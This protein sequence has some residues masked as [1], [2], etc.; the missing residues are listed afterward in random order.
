MSDLFA[1]PLEEMIEFQDLKTDLQ[2]G[3]GPLLVTG[4]LDSQKV[5]LLSE[6]SDLTPWKLIVTYDDSRAREICEDYRCFDTDISLYPARDLLFYTSDIHGNLLTKQRIQVM[7]RILESSGGVVVT[8]IDGLMEH[9]LP[10]AWMKERSLTI[11]AED[12][13][14]VGKLTHALAEMGYE[15]VA[16]VEGSG[17]FS[18]R[19]GIID[20]FPLTEEVPYRI[21]LWG[22]E[23][24]SIRTFDPESQRSIEQ[25]DEAVIYP[26]TEMALTPEQIQDG[27]E[28]IE[29]DRR[30]Y[31]K[32]LRDAM[33]TEEA[34]RMDS[35]VSEVLEGL[36]EGFR[37]HG[38]GSYIRYFCKET[39]SFL[40][41]FPADELTIFLDEPLRLKEKAETTETE[42][43]ESMSHRLEGG[44]L[45][46]GQ[47][48]FLYSAKETLAMAMR[49]RTLLLLGLDQKLSGMT[50]KKK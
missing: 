14:E 29:K 32:K 24:D 42:F 35:A 10:L 31:V 30:K 4:C 26:A 13:V 7:R 23:V 22:D 5:H 6:L 28:A 38:L 16:Q 12:V 9:L 40:N 46:P 20:I 18:V 41:Y 27:T 45:L 21:E 44:Y 36:R 34:Y 17:Q 11:G 19:G 37:V 1:N 47:T 3:Q 39:V 8:T 33:K 2:R 48:S 50:V 15:K 25:V 43:R 49:P